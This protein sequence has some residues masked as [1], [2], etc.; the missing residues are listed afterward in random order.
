MSVYAEINIRNMSLFSFRNY[1]QSDIVR[2]FFSKDDYYCIPNYIDEPYD[3]DLSPYTKH[4]YKTSVLKAKQRLD[5]LG[6]GISRLEQLFND[7]MKDAIYYDAFL[8]HLDFESDEFIEEAYNKIKKYITFNKWTNS[9][10]KVTEYQLQHG[11]ICDYTTENIKDTGFNTDCD[12]IIYYSLKDRNYN[13][14]YGIN[15]EIIHFAYIFRLILE[16]CKDNDEIILDFSYFDD[17]ADDCIPKAI[18]ATEIDEKIIVLVEGTSDKDILEF[19][20]KMIYP[21]LFDLFYFM[22]FDDGS[23]GKRDGGTSFLIKSMK[24][25]YFSKIK[26][27]FIAIF[28]N[29]AEGYNSKCSL[30]NE[31]KNWPDNFRILLYPDNKLFH[32]YPTILPNNSI[33]ND[34]INKKACSIELY[35]PDT[36]IQN[37]GEY[38]PIEWESRI[39]IKN[40]NKET[41]YQYQ[42]V[43]SNKNEIKQKFHEFK[44]KI[45]SKKQLFNLEEWSRMKS[46]IDSIVFAFS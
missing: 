31:I 2:L 13:S 42:G 29:D 37:Q 12:K 14:F 46:V 35:L 4:M 24:T 3:E 15:I 30:I 16:S 32:C 39:K 5:A 1:L 10:R 36:I 6:Y 45:E 27:K 7:N 33:C 17:W 22:D 9:M 20:L 40:E 23:G 41:E 8:Y 25:F 19:S 34:N 18:S 38:S 28:D 21:H 44:K 11:N 43:I 26:S